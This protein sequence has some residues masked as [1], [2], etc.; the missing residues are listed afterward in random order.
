MKIRTV[1]AILTAVLAAAGL[2]AQDFSAMTG[3]GIR[4]ITVNNENIRQIT[5]EGKNI[6]AG[7][8]GTDNKNIEIYFTEKP[9]N[10]EQLKA[11]E[12]KA[13]EVSETG[14]KITIDKKELK[15]VADR[16]SK[17]GNYL[18]IFT[19][20]DI[21]VIVTLEAGGLT[22]K[23]IRGELLLEGKSMD[24]EIT[25][26][27]GVINYRNKS[28]NLKADNF[29]GVMDIKT[30]SGDIRLNKISGSLTVENTSGD[31]VLSSFKGKL[32]STFQVGDIKISGSDFT[33]AEI[34]NQ[35][36]DVMVS[37]SKGEKLKMVSSLGDIKVL[38]S[39]F[40]M[41]KAEINAGELTLTDVA[42]DVDI[43]LNLG[44][45]DITGF[46]MAGKAD[47]NIKVNFGDIDIGLSEPASYDYFKSE[48]DEKLDYNP[49]MEISDGTRICKDK[50][51]LRF[52]TNMGTITVK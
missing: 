18:T 44:E 5:C 20:K 17:D 4:K 43:S 34:N 26:V 31:F 32:K 7:V 16:K 19:P 21:S 33:D 9:M 1:I 11:A 35:S 51:C 39:K 23:G 10:A 52:K 42:S 13:G 8:F 15:I 49:G 36:G 14:A 37:G 40:D 6:T 46:K 48:K 28:G 38:A 3:A 27:S 29:E 41:I 45:L 24:T 25:D 50:K 47:S 22:V 12:L 2:S 30:F